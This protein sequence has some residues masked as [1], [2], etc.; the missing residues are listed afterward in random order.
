MSLK[1]SSSRAIAM[2]STTL[3][4]WW[5]LLHQPS[6]LEHRRLP[7]G[8]HHLWPGF[9]RFFEEIPLES[10]ESKGT[11]VV[12]N[13]GISP[14]IPTMLDFM[15]LIP[16]KLGGRFQCCKVA[17]FTTIR[18]VTK[19][20]FQIT[21]NTYSRSKIIFMCVNIYKHI[22]MHIYIYGQVSR[23]PIPELICGDSRTG[24][25]LGVTLADTW[26]L[27]CSHF[28][29]WSGKSTVKAKVQNPT[30]SAWDNKTWPTAARLLISCFLKQHQVGVWYFV[31]TFLQTL[32]QLVIEDLKRTDQIRGF[33]VV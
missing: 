15:D 3:V 23:L 33:L 25:P 21:E 5:Q 19:Q 31:H 11:M 14:K 18:I 26:K 2:D 17:L 13:P 16:A 7:L 27:T 6:S 4:L 28:P 22:Y 9:R 8:I 10:R 20:K 30:G 32:K 29:T 12:H 1:L 24:P